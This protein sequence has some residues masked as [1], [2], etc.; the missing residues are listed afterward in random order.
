MFGLVGIGIVVAIIATAVY[1]RWHVQHQLDA[2]VAMREWDVAIERLQGRNDPASMLLLAQYYRRANRLE[3]ATAGLQRCRDAGIPPE[4][5]R[6]EANLLAVQQG[7]LARVERY[8]LP[9]L[10]PQREEFLLVAEVMTQ[11]WMRQNRLIDTL[12]VLNQWVDQYP[13]DSEAYIRRGWVHEHMLR[14]DAALADYEKAFAL[15]A[16]R[17]PLRLHMAQLQLNQ[18]R[19]DEALALLVGARDDNA[20]SL[21]RAQAY[22]LIGRGEEA[23]DELAKIMPA[24]AEVERE[25]GILALEQNRLPDAEKHL[26]SAYA[27]LPYDRAVVY[28]L[29]QCLERQGKSAEVAPI[30]AQLVR[31]DADRKRLNQLMLIVLQQPKEVASRFEIGEIFARNGLPEEAIRWWRMVLE[32][33]PG[34]LP[35]Q[36]RLKGSEVK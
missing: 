34:H 3:E 5:I 26:R 27:T 11:E 20:V 23:A 7:E 19:P 9:L 6:L 31:I 2:A 17:Q 28:S 12:G 29:V 22:R 1:W 18:S 30:A 4:A 16:R 14:A 13:E 33:E 36:E 24:T 10:K 25:L 15:D 8:L 21:A 35:S 32:I